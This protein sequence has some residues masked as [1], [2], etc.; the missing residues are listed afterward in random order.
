[1][2]VVARLLGERFREALGQP[3][4]VENRV[5]A[6]GNLGT[7]AA[8]KAPGDGYTLVMGAANTHA[9]NFSLFKNPGFHAID[10]FT[11]VSLIAL[12]PNV[13]TL[14]ANVPAS[15][16]KEFIAY[17]KANP[18]KLNYGSNGSG[19]TLHMIAEMFK[20]VHGLYIVHIP[21]S[22]QGPLTQSL[23]SGEIHVVFN[24]I[25]NVQAL[26]KA[27]QLKGIAVTLPQR[28]PELPNVP[29]FAEAG[30]KGFEF[31]S[32][33]ALFGPAR[34]PASIVETLNRETLA[35]LKI[36][37]VRTR[38]AALGTVVMGTSAAELGKFQRDEVARWA[39]VVKASGATVD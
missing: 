4:I 31:S 18:G 6:T 3:F 27:N 23:I 11:P 39:Q 1:V 8:A 38:I 20:K 2:D 34:M 10:D 33:V 25:S 12:A 9:I 7:A 24:N 32:W 19:S 15:N 13:M 30:V 14:N 37:E 35:A 28:W 22:G 26:I 36:P 5:G 29:T 16:V 21:F 17:A